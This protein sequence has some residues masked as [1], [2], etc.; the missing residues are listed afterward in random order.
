[1][2]GID[3]RASVR[4]S[5]LIGTYK[6]PCAGAARSSVH[7]RCL[8]CY[9]QFEMKGSYMDWQH[10]ESKL[11]PRRPMT[12]ASTSSALPE[13][14]SLALLRISY[15]TVSGTPGSRIPAATP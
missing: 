1:M 12:T 4:R 5:T 6:S 2:L 8:G 15:G 3:R 9:P 10:F 13:R 11:S 7:A 14:R